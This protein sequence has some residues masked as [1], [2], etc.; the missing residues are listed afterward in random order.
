MHSAAANGNE[1]LVELLLAEGADPEA[2]TDDGKTPLDLAA[3]RGH[4]VVAT[5]LS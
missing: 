3:E 2:R 5:L 1:A 4:E